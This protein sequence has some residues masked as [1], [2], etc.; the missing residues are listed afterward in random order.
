M[1]G[2]DVC[3][4]CNLLMALLLQDCWCCML[5]GLLWYAA[6]LCAL[7]DNVGLMQVIEWIQVMVIVVWCSYVDVSMMLP[8]LGVGFQWLCCRLVVG[9]WI[10]AGFQCIWPWHGWVFCMWCVHDYYFDCAEFCHELLILCRWMILALVCCR[11]CIW[12][13]FM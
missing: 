11:V 2:H 9:C 4:C 8:S 1:F 12:C 10:A 7:Q 6:E 3:G 13:K 5:Q